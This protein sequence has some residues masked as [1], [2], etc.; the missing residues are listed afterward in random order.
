MNE[1]EDF[2]PCEDCVQPDGCLSR[3]SIQEYIKENTDIAF[4]RGET[5]KQLWGDTE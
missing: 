3:C 5:P 2:T 4:Q 1:D